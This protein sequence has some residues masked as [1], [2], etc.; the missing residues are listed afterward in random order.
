LQ[1][2]RNITSN[3]ALKATFPMNA[4]FV[5]ISHKISIKAQCIVE[6]PQYADQPPSA[7]TVVA[8]IKLASSDAR[9]NA[10]PA[11]SR[12][13][14]VRGVNIKPGAI[15]SLNRS[16]AGNLEKSIP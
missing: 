7:T 12:G 6:M 13:S 1:L 10:S 11:T 8:L 9:N 5:F 14:A 2:E 16:A 15:L 4:L 3:I